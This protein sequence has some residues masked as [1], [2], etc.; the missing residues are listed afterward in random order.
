M[1]KVKRLNANAL[2]I[3]ACISMVIDHIG[4][5]F[6]P[7]IK[8]FRILGR[9]AFPIF[10][11]FLA[12][13]CY[14]TR[15]KLKHFL[16]L[17]IVASVCQIVYYIAMKSTNMSILTT[18]C[19]SEALI[20]LL[21]YLKKSFIE[22]KA[23]ISFV[24]MLTLF[25]GIILTYYACEK[26]IIDYG[27]WGCMTPLIISLFSFGKL[28]VNDKIKKLDCQATELILLGVSILLLPLSNVLGWINFFSLFAIVL[29]LFYNGEKGK[30]NMKYFFYIF[31]PLHLCVLEGIAMLINLI[32]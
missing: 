27:F 19:I 13:G 26:I 15:N 9:L 30:Y 5:M 20:Y 17:F 1:N 21:F 16:T 4:F 28:P 2:K 6:F 29:L 14:Y 24:L 25:S 18:F 22:N 3:I 7:K 31:Y 8:I 32:K 10:A 23:V 11:Y 12:K